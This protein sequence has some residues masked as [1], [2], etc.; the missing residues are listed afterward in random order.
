MRP[1]YLVE[2]PQ[3]VLGGSIDIISTRVVG[4]EIPQRRSSQFVFEEIHFVEEKDDTRPH[5]PS[6]VHHRIEKNQTF[7]HT[8]LL[9]VSL[10]CPRKVRP[11][12]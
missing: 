10:V 11:H 6:R 8:I 12:T 9:V 4:E 2:S 5:E 1:I 7:H 3:Q